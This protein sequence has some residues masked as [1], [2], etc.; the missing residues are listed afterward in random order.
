MDY[1]IE[2]VR[3]LAE[4]A[5]IVLT[6]E[7]EGQ[8]CHSLGALHGIAEILEQAP[9]DA[10]ADDPFLNARPLSDWREDRAMQWDGYGAW[11]EAVESADGF[12]TVP[13]VVE[14]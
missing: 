4:I 11:A 9:I 8:L 12:F 3:A 14:E 13:R 7:E 2:R 5:R 10:E 6:E 1:S